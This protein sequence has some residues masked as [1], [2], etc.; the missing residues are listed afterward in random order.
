MGAASN[1]MF[2]LEA[3]MWSRTHPGLNGLSGQVCQRTTPQIQ[4]ASD[5]V[6]LATARSQQHPDLGM[7]H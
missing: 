7:V 3:R 5:D 6:T 1:A 4:P 2:P